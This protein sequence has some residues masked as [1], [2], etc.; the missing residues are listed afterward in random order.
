MLNPTLFSGF[1]LVL[2]GCAAKTATPEAAPEAPAAEVPAAAPAA[3]AD[4]GIQWMPV[5]AD[6]PDGPQL[7]LL[8][9]NPKEGAFS[10]LVKLP[11]GHASPLHT[12]PANF[13]AVVVSGTIKNGRTA[14]DS[15]ELKAGD[16]WTQPANEAHFTGCTEDADCIFV[17]NMDGA[18]GT[19]PAEEAVEASTQTVVAAAD[20]AFAPM[21]P[22]KP[23]GPNLVALTGDM[24]TG[25]WTALARFP[26]GLSTPK[27]SHSAN[28]SGVVVSGVVSNGGDETFS[29]GSVWSNAAGNVH[30]TICAED[31]DC[32][33]FIT[34]DGAMEMIP[35]E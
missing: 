21:N 18:M 10:A 12:H 33:F 5:Y 24:K 30:T 32:V 23:E 7:S 3:A 16:M 22:E 2:G 1:I 20:I 14:E 9:G 28:Y 29:A 8:A 27:H 19:T 26:A 6:Q 17:G 34:M 11:A 4:A 25:P 35:A 15:P 31:Q 13:Q